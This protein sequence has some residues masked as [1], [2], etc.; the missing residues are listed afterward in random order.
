MKD[1]LAID[2]RLRQLILWQIKGGK[3]LAYNACRDGHAILAY[4]KWL[5]WCHDHF[6][7]Q[8]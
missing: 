1:L 7:Q 3:A 4:C 2:R 8:R 5:T 6:A